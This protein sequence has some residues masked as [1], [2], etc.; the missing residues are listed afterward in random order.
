M[1]TTE[2]Y[3]LKTGSRFTVRGRE[4]TFHDWAGSTFGARNGREYVTLP[5]FGPRGGKAFITV[6]P[7]D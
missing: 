1:S 2:V 6:Y 4:Y 7:T 3:A 5:V